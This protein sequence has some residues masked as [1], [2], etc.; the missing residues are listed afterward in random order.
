MLHVS[1]L[2]EKS[3]L[4]CDASVKGISGIFLKS[5]FLQEQNEMHSKNIKQIHKAF[6]NRVF[7]FHL[8]LCLCKI[9]VYRYNATVGFVNKFCEGSDF[10]L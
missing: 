1:P 9:V 3:H 5:D 2:S 8:N 6:L 4:N 7:V 10:L